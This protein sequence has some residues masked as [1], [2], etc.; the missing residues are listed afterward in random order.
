MNLRQQLI[1]TGLFSE[2]DTR[3]L[4]ADSCAE[5]VQWGETTLEYTRVRLSFDPFGGLTA[6][7][8][9]VFDPAAREVVA[10]NRR[11]LGLPPQHSKA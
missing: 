11:A 6:V 9:Y 8:S 10:G 2:T 3:D 5:T 7:E 4:V 1:D